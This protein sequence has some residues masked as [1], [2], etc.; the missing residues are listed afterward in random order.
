MSASSQQNYLHI[1]YI[2]ADMCDWFMQTSSTDKFKRYEMCISDTRQLF[3]SD[4]LLFVSLSDLL[5]QK[6]QEPIIIPKERDAPD[7]TELLQ[8]SA[9]EHLTTFRQ[10]EARDFGSVRTIATTDFEALYAYKRGDYQQCLQLSLQNVHTLLDGDGMADIQTLPEFIQLFDDDIVSLIALTLI[11]NPSSRYFVISQVT[12]T[13]YLITQCQLKLR[14][15]VTS[16]ALTLDYIE[17]AQRSHPAVRTLD[18][19]TL[20][21]IERKLTA[22][23]STLMV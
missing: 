19:L 8:K 6:S 12:L 21:L 10:I 2:S 15:S 20:K 7:L 23:I 9:V 4:V 18:H 13:L 14:H 17:V 3:T 11:V 22:N 1:K 5:K 16:Q